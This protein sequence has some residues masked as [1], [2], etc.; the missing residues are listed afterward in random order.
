MRLFYLFLSITFFSVSLYSQNCPPPG[1]PNSG[2]N[3]GNP[4]ICENL[5]DY[6]AEINNSNQPR[7]FP[8][9]AG[10]QL[11]N[12]EWFGFFAGTTTITL[13]IT[14][15]NC[16]PG[17]QQGLQ[18]AIYD[19][20]PAFPPPGGWCT[21]NLMDAQCACTEDPF[22]LTA[23]DFVVG[24]VY[25]LVID[26]CSGNVCDYVIQVL[27]GSTVGFPPDDPGVVTGPT[28]VCQGTAAD[29]NVPPISG[30]TIYTWT[31]SP[32]NAGT[33][34][35]NNNN[36]DITVTWATGFSGTAT[37]CVKTSNQCFSNPDESCITVTV[38]P[39]P[40][41]TISGGGTICTNSGGSVN[42]TVTLTG[43]PDWEFVYAINGVPQPAIITSSSPYTIIATQSGNYTL[44]SV[45][46]IDSDPD[47]AGTVSGTATVTAITLNPS[48]IV[49]S[50]V[51]GQSNGSVDLS[52]TGGNA[53]YSYSWSGGQ[54]TQDLSNVSPGAYTVTITDN[55]SCTATHTATVNDN[56]VNPTLSAIITNNTS[57]ANDNGAIDLSVSP[58]GSYNYSW[59]NG[60]T[61]QDLSNLAGGTY[62]VTVTQGLSC[63]ASATY[64]VND[65]PNAPNPTATPTN[66]SCDLPNGSINASVSGGVAPYTFEWSN[67]ATTEDLA[68]IIAGTY[69]LTVTGANNCTNTISVA[70]NNVNPAINLSG[71]VINNTTCNG[72]NGSINLMVTPA[73]NY[74]YEWSNGATTEDISSLPPGAYTV[75][76][77][78]GGSCTAEAS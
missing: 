15:S 73:N 36:G 48:S 58:A 65:V 66:S 41:A 7:N 17:G 16:D 69:E 56:I 42:L 11:N 78:A 45:N 61:T 67:G 63:S 39:K 20:C 26:G 32:S 72:G 49:V 13:E 34:S 55:N 29:Y 62:M 52:V 30:A 28:P 2:S 19:N 59:S 50:A 25:W 70:V 43:E 31:L 3:C 46:S 5:D 74:T 54:T 68:N 1:F 8:C 10:W 71:V 18:A 4:I 22:Q 77:S 33:L 40:T 51:C 53:P 44:V 47:C 75:T 76:V 9:C 21:D 57:C 60:A 6:C 27:E 38:I 12:D 14:P 37:L 64:I 35:N 23:T 24:E